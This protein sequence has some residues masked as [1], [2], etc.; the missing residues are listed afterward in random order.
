MPTTP[1][2]SPPSVRKS[3]GGPMRLTIGIAGMLLLGLPVQDASACSCAP[4]ISFW[5][6]AEAAKVVAVVEVTKH[7]QGGLEARIIEVVKGTGTRELGKLANPNPANMCEFVPT[8]DVG[9][10]HALVLRPDDPREGAFSICDPRTLPVVKDQRQ[11][12][13]VTTAVEL[14]EKLN[15]GKAP[16]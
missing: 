12:E 5:K 6:T 4:G 14:R 8:L 16:R 11:G 7:L 2:P 13:G 1:I 15:A 3:E 9:T 10:V